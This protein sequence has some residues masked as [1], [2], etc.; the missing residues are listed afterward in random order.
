MF[1]SNCGKE[2]EKN[3]R[4]C[5]ACNYPSQIQELEDYKRIKETDTWLC[6][7]II[8]V[9]IIL[10]LIFWYIQTKSSTGSIYISY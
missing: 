3:T 7:V 10:L 8:L 2:I 9:L 5:P 4:F 6:I 1:C